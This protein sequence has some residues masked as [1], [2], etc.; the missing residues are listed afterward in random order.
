MADEVRREERRA[1]PDARRGSRFRGGQQRRWQRRARRC[2]F[3]VE[4]IKKID[5]KEAEM[6]R[7]FLND[8]GKI[9]PRRQTGTCARHQRQLSQAI[10]RARHMAL[11]PFTAEHIRGG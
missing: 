10:K 8:R 1:Q 3:C 11:L 7:R 2:Y 9:R 5:Y 6:I 4:G